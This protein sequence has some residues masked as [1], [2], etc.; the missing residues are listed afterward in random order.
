MLIDNLS[1]FISLPTTFC[2]ITQFKQHKNH[3]SFSELAILAAKSKDVND[4]NTA[5]HND[6]AGQLVTCK[7]VDTDLNQDDVFNYPTKFL[8]LLDLP[9]MLPHNV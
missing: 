7:S 9:G 5:I 2:S 6:I 1:G 8:K 4:L 3:V